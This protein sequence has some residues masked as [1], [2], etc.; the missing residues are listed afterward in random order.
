MTHPTCRTAAARDLPRLRTLWQLCFGD[1][2]EDIDRLLSLLYAPGRGLV[3]EAE[4]QAESMLL[5]L[6]M[7]LVGQ[8][9][10]TRPVRYVYAFCTHPAAQGRGY[11][12]ALLAWAEQRAAAKGCAAVVMVPGEA[13][14]FDFYEGLGYQRDF[15]R[16]T[17]A[18]TAAALPGAAATAVTPEEYGALRETLLTGTAHFRYP[19][20][21]LQ[22]Q[23]WL[24]RS[25]G[26][27]LYT[28]TAGDSLW[29]AAAEGGEGDTLLLRE[30]LGPAEA[31]PAAASALGEA[32][33]RGRWLLH[34]PGQGAPYGVVKWLGEERTEGCWLGL[35]LE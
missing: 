23:Q 14:L 30:L 17:L 15:P 18:G 20:D 13:S 21:I 34:T 2:A 31:A 33:G 1:D 25:S 32:L 22:A 12:R 10:E 5:S 35:S 29:L 8:S 26:G 4:G 27:G 28:V 6:P 9:G 7:T 24:S 11:G 3:L 19:A 16:R